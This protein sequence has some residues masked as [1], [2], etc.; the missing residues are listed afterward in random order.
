MARLG[1]IVFVVTF[2]ALLAIGVLVLLALACRKQREKRL[3]ELTKLRLLS[4]PILNSLVAGTL[5]YQPALQA[6]GET[7]PSGSQRAQVVERLLFD[8]KLP[9]SISVPLL[10]RLAMDFGLVRLWERNLHC[11]GDPVPCR[12]AAFRR[13]RVAERVG[14][15]HPL[16]RARSAAR[17]GL[18]RYAPSW[19]LLVQALE[20]AY[21]DVRSAAAFA[22]GRIAE[23][24]SFP[25]LVD[26]LLHIVLT[27]SAG[28]SLRDIKASLVCFPLRQATE[29]M[30]ALKHSHPRVRFLA[31]EVI[32]E[33]VESAAAAEAGLVLSQ[34]RFAPELTELFL[35]RLVFDENPDVRARAA[36]VIARLS[37]PRVPLRLVTLLDDAQWFVRLHAVRALAQPRLITLVEHVSHRLTDVNWRVREA[38]VGAL[39]S[40]GPK[41][42]ERLLEHFL[43]TQDRYSLEQIAEGL[44]RA[45]LLPVQQ[46]ENG[47][48]GGWEKAQVMEQLIGLGKTS[49][50]EAG[51]DSGANDG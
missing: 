29:L 23:P 8:G 33:M 28:L 27:P 14:A 25:A 4:F 22:L 30:E 44:Q 13:E 1:E 37:D 24:L 15:P 36:P 11:S 2:S 42:A 18:I 26:R 32:R 17:L 31:A 39:L 46:G 45:G 12:E 5:D 10:R 9:A 3:R 21:P 40:L 41:G 20:D 6:L 51:L 50:L 16:A 38:A 49:Y 19:P 7:L 35:A 34:E 48:H 47:H 43:T